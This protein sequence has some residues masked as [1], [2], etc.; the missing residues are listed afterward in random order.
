VN[1]ALVAANRMNFINNYILQFPEQFP[2]SFSTKI[3]FDGTFGNITN[4]V[5]S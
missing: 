5:I 1:P 4:S 2:T 3:Y